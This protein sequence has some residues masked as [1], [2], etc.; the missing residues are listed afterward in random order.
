MS[1]HTLHS[2]GDL[3]E[4][5]QPY[6]RISGSEKKEITNITGSKSKPLRA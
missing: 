4:K 1:G 6:L 5:A 2:S 3:M